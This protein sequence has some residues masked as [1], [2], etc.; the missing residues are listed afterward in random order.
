[1]R[2][3]AAGVTAALM[4]LVAASCGSSPSTPTTIAHVG[5]L[6]GKTAGQVLSAAISAAGAQRTAHY[7]M[8]ARN[9][10]QTQTISGDAGP[11]EGQQTVTQGKQQIKVVYVGSVAYVQ[12][13]ASGLSS[14]MGLKPATAST[15]AGKW[16]AIH[17]TDSLYN[18]IAKSV[19]LVSTLTQLEPS[20]RL[21]LTGLSTAAGRQVIAVRGGLPGPPQSGVSGSATYYIA[22]SHPTL[23]L[24]FSGAVQS[25]TQSAVDDGTFSAWGAPLHLQVPAPTVEFSSIPTT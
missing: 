24:R 12:G 21:T 17:K 9:A 13:N 19:T 20:G 10:G 4:G 23:P 18:S 11:N 1:M 5:D 2:T 16:I 8:T 25:G 14:V 22:T 7:V 3:L 15:Y 6:A